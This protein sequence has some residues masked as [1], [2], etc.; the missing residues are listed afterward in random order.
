MDAE[1]LEVEKYIPKEK[2]KRKR[3]PVAT[4]VKEMQE[5]ILLLFIPW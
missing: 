1:V 5:K 4:T 3:N 2:N